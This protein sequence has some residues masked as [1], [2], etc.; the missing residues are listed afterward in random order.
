MLECCLLNLR[1]A[2]GLTPWLRRA[3][4]TKEL[5]VATDAKG[6]TMWRSREDRL[7]IGNPVGELPNQDGFRFLGVCRDGSRLACSVVKGGD[8]MHRVSGVEFPELV[9]WLRLI[10]VK[11]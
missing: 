4:R 9:G 11:G 7:R 8:G 2:S 6:L 10:P 1:E 3:C 5:T